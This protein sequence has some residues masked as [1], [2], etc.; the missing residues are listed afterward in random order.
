MHLL[1][2][3]PWCIDRKQTF[4]SNE[5]LN[6]ILCINYRGQSGYHKQHINSVGMVYCLIDLIDR[7]EMNHWALYH[8]QVIG[9][10]QVITSN[11]WIK[12]LMFHFFQFHVCIHCI[13]LYCC[14]FCTQTSVMYALK[15]MQ[16]HLIYLFPCR[17][18]EQYFQICQNLTYVASAC[19]ADVGTFP[20][21]SWEMTGYVT[22]N[23]DA[24]FK[25]MTRDITLRVSPSE[26]V[27]PHE[28]YSPKIQQ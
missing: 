6:L 2:Q 21:W 10:N 16:C 24:G 12:Y 13:V 17:L 26:M 7:F 27:C 14:T 28:K 19:T 8:V 20:R 11:A 3:W 23:R 25:G 15:N 5:P 1:V 4:G 22:W 18:Q 9:V